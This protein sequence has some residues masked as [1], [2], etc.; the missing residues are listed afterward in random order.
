M[1]GDEMYVFITFHHL[2]SSYMFSPSGV[3]I[4]YNLCPE[5][6]WILWCHLEKG[7]PLVRDP[8]VRDPLV[9]EPCG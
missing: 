6:G 2:S 4:W 3:L 1:K 9:Q 5:M 8:L 7:G